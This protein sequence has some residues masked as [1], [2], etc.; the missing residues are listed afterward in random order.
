M[1]GSTQFSYKGISLGATLDFRYGGYIYS[2]TKDYQGWTG[3]GDWTVMNNRNPFV[4]PNSVVQNSDGTYSPNSVPVS[5]AN[6][7]TFYSDGGFDKSDFF[8]IDRSYLKLR[9]VNLSYS[10]PKSI[11]DKMRLSGLK[12]SFNVGNILLWTPQENNVIDPETTTFGND[13]EAK[14]GEFGVNPSYVT[15]VFGLNFSF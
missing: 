10:L 3:N 13:L 14:F 11:C 15:Y 1:G 8:V 6:F 7:H 2:R 9:D 12:L 4:I 5:A